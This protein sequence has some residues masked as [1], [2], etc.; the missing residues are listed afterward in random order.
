[1]PRQPPVPISAKAASIQTPP[2]SQKKSRRGRLYTG[3]PKVATKFL[4]VLNEDFR[5]LK[6]ALQNLNTRAGPA[7]TAVFPRSSP[8]G[9]FREEERRDSATKIPY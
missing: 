8:Q 5:A 4:Y 7:K 6:D 9:T 3:Y 2:S 1:M